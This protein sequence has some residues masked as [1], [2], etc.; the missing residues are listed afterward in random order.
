[1]KI[2]CQGCGKVFEGKGTDRY[3][4]AECR[5]RTR[6]ERKT[7]QKEK[8]H[9]SINAKTCPYCKQ[10]FMPKHRNDQIYCSEKCREKARWE[11]I[12]PLSVERDCLNCGIAFMPENARQKYCSKQCWKEKYYSDNGERIRERTRKYRLNNLEREKENNRRY[13]EANK[14][15]CKQRDLKY[16]DI[17]CFGGNRQVALER[18]GYKCVICGATKELIVHHKDETGQTEKPN[19]TLENLMTV[20]KACHIEIHKPTRWKETRHKIVY[21]QTCGKKM[22]INNARIADNR[23]KYCSKECADKAKTTRVTI[24]CQHCGKPFEVQPARLKRGKVKYCSMECRKAA[25]SASR[26]KK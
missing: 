19:N 5:E 22:T 26:D 8:K 11:R 7:I 15:Q 14:E 2:F 3:C 13:R 10:I 24:P 18:D 17:T 1:M 4:S 12:K 16:H 9:K 25:G 20:C 21:C 23:G 6:A